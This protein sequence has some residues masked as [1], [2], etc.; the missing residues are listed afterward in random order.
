MDG[1]FEGSPLLSAALAADFVD[2][3]LK[4]WWDLFTILATAWVYFVLARRL[5]VLL[6]LGF[7]AWKHASVM[8][9]FVSHV[10]SRY[11]TDAA[12]GI[13]GIFL[14]GY[15]VSTW[16]V[17]HRVNPT[18]STAPPLLIP[19]RI[20]HHRLYLQ[21]H[22]F[23]YP[24]LMFGIPIE[25]SDN[26]NGII[27]ANVHDPWSWF[28]QLFGLTALFDVCPADHLQRLRSDN[29]LGGKLDAYLESEGIDASRYPYAYLVTA[30][31]FPGG[32]RFNPAT[33]WFLYSSDKVHQAIILEMNNVFGERHPY[34]VAR[35]LQKE[36]EHIHNMTQND[37]RFHVSPFNSRKGSY[38]ILAKDPLGPGMQGFRGLDISITLSSS[39]GQPK[40]VANL[41]S[42]GEAI[43][44][45]RISILGRVGFVS[46]W[47][48]SVLTIL[49]RFMM[50][51]TILFFMH[52]LHF[53]Y[54]PEPLKDSIGRSANWIEKILEQ[55]F[56]KYLKYLVQR[57]TAPVTILY[58]PGGVA[59]A[60][61]ETFISHSTCGPGDS[62]CEIKIKVLTPIFYSRFVY[63]AHDSEAI[64]CEVA[65]SCTL[66]TDKPE[67]LTRVFLKKGSP[68]I[69]AS[70]LLDYM[71]FQL[72]KNLRRRPDKIE[73]PLTSTNGHSSS[74][75]GIDIRDFRMSSMDAFVLEQGDKELKNAYLRSVVRLFVADRIAMSSVGLLGM[76]ELIGRVGVSWVLALL[77]TETI[78]GFS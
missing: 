23:S 57:S 73:R 43:D 77:I 70:N 39:K 75:K 64:F 24:Y 5:D 15:Y 1:L 31:Q 21:K 33:F 76:M 54:R 30:A 2:G 34:L 74:V 59:E 58:M 12:F 56:R 53:W 37:Q 3:L 8:T 35:E 62:A 19:G 67:Q 65:E 42:E 9:S 50:Q 47:F 14:V 63:Y 51:S 13:C 52:N 4:R 36:E 25:V 28:T 68:P 11:I 6:T 60:S 48:G 55:V 38:S 45:Y 29:G 49:P 40:L 27:F 26:A 71:H 17:N 78:L 32:F 61:E 20:T 18:A 44:P 22:S 16:I 10:K 41:F 46:S 66:W 69:H 72:I 7:V